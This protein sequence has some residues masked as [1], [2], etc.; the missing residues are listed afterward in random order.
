MKKMKVTN[1]MKSATKVWKYLRILRL[2]WHEFRLSR[3]ELKFKVKSEA[4]RLKWEILRLC[5][6]QLTRIGSN[7]IAGTSINAIEASWK[8]LATKATSFLKIIKTIMEP[9]AAIYNGIPILK[10]IMKNVKNVASASEKMMNPILMIQMTYLA[11]Y[12]YRSKQMYENTKETKQVIKIQCHDL[13]KASI[14]SLISVICCPGS[15]HLSR[16]SV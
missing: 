4:L 16:I 10:L 9:N 5:N 13:I 7:M 8:I 1:E 2:N 3:L 12:R 15:I 14:L 6:Q 11:K